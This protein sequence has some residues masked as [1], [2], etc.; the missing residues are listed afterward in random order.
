MK[1]KSLT[2]LPMVSSGANGRNCNVY[3]VY[4]VCLLKSLFP[5]CHLMRTIQLRITEFSRTVTT[6]WAFVLLLWGPTV[7]P[8]D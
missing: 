7:W 8:Y 6:N 3:I 4:S 2:K 5:I 1:S